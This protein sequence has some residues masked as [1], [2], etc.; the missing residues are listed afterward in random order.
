LDCFANS[1]TSSD[2]K[3]LVLPLT[4]PSP[5]I[6]REKMGRD[7]AIEAAKEIFESWVRRIRKSAPA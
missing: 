4:F 1:E 5:E 7:E 3:K 2:Q 6:V